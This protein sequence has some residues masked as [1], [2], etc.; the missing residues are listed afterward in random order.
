[1]SQN[2]LLDFSDLPR[3]DAIKPEHITPALDVLLADARAA[4][5][6]VVA[7]GGDSWDAVVEPLTDATEKLGR[8]WGVVGHLNGVVGNTEACARPTT[9][10][11][12]ASPPSSPSWG[13]TWTCSPASRR[14]RPIPHSPPP[15][16]RRRK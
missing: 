10:K 11:S 12:R 5:D 3:F 15:A 14:W 13:R 7:A 8:A 2:P 16:P 4:I 1:M 6:A 9:P